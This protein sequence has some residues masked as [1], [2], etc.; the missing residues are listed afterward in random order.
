MVIKYLAILTE[1]RGSYYYCNHQ[2]V[3]TINHADTEKRKILD[4]YVISYLC[5]DDSEQDLAPVSNK[6]D[7]AFVRGTIPKTK[8]NIGSMG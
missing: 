8:S 3:C 1:G 7:R 4:K 5:K 2:N 6:K